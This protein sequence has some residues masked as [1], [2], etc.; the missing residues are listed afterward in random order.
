[1]TSQPDSMFLSTILQCGRETDNFERDQQVQQQLHQ[2]GEKESYREHFTKIK[3]AVFIYVC[4]LV[5][6]YLWQ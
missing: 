2:K 3:W 1:M 4:W 5:E 6:W